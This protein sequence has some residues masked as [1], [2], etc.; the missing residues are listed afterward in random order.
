MKTFRKLLISLNGSEPEAII[1][2]LETQSS[3]YW[4]HNTEKDHRIEEIATT[5]YCFTYSENAD[6][7]QLPPRPA[8]Y[9][10]KTKGHFFC[11]QHSASRKI[12]TFLR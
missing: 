11:Y 8:L 12:R 2:K 1:K 7:P 10:G 4:Y 9:S 5:V 3:Q 6:K